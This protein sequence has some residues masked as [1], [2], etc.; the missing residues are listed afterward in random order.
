MKKIKK[1]L[2]KIFE[3]NLKLTKENETIGGQTPYIS[4]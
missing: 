2:I 1:Q 3:K 4:F